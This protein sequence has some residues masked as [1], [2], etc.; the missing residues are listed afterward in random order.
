MARGDK[1]IAFRVSVE[2]L[3]KLEQSASRAGLTV[4]KFA[5]QA[6][7]GAKVKP[8]VIDVATGR[9][10]VA[11]L[12]KIGSNINQIARRV[13]GGDV[14]A[15][16]ELA[17]VNEQI[18]KFWE[19]LVNGKL[20]KTEKPAPLLSGKDLHDLEE[21]ADEPPAPAEPLSKKERS[22]QAERI[23]PDCGGRLILKNGRNGKFYGCENYP[24]CRH[25]ED[26]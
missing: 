14:S 13:N 20:P 6:A 5:K 11:E 23:C 19:L 22:E 24:K 8:Q 12:G 10:C 1:Q 16:A 18:D 4:P 9:A 15:S 7:L 3:A 17:A 21:S 25:T 2:E 26:F